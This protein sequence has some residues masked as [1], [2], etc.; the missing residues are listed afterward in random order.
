MTDIEIDIMSAL[1]IV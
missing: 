1:L